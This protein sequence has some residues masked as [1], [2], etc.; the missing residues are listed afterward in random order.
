MRRAEPRTR[1]G[2]GAYPV[3]HCRS[4]VGRNE[5]VGPAGW[6][7]PP[8]SLAGRRKRRRAAARSR[9]CPR[10]GRRGTLS[11]APE[12]GRDLALLLALRGSVELYGTRLAAGLSEP[13]IAEASKGDVVQP[14]Q[15]RPRVESAQPGGGD[16]RPRGTCDGLHD[17]PVRADLR[18][19]GSEAA[20]TRTHRG[21]HRHRSAHR[22]TSG[23]RSG[24]AG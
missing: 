1:C 10:E 15:H 19:A 7:P 23:G 22:R 2:V 6:Q 4:G 11:E 8:R 13:V 20:S 16:A 12:R 24:Q 14:A 9:S 3:E 18:R 17:A 21:A 5:S